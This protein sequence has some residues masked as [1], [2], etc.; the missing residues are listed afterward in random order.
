MGLIGRPETSV[1]NY[2]HTLRN[3][4]DARRSLLFCGGSL[5]SSCTQ[6]SGTT[7]SGTRLLWHF[8]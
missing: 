8:H 3:I 2:H 5:K 7:L 1:R 4:P 6:C